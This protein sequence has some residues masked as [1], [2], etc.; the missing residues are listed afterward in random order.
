MRLDRLSKWDRASVGGKFG[1]HLAN[2]WEK[3]WHKFVPQQSGSR[4]AMA[5]TPKLGIQVR[6]IQIPKKNAQ[7]LPPN[8]VLDL[9]PEDEQ[10][11]WLHAEILPLGFRVLGVGFGVSG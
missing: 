1:K 5:M 9:W 7:L 11:H 10:K 2:S 3:F 4:G 6:D 8:K